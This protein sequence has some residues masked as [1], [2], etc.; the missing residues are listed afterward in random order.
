LVTLA[1]ALA[2]PR[3]TQSPAPPAQGQPQLQKATFAGGCFWCTEAIFEELRGVHK[4]D[5]GYTGGHT[6]NPNYKAVCKGD[7]GH[8]EAVE[9][10]YDP[11]QLSYLQLLEVFFETHDPTSA[12][13]QASV[14][15]GQYRSEIF[16]HTP[17]QKADAESVIA[18]LGRSGV[19]Q[20]PVVT[21]VSA[22]GPWFRAE[23]Y[24][25]EFYS[26]NPGQAYCYMEI[27]PKLQKFREVFAHRLKDKAPR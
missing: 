23:D 26:E 20:K 14:P 9:I 2:A 6:T 10:R 24:H 13:P 19:Y 15:G 18:E 4:V 25:Q 7:T 12:N 16:Y 11:E 8:A 3:Q 17:E 27:R 21:R 5:S 1:L 22:A